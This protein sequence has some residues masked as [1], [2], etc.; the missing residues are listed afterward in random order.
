MCSG[1]GDCSQNRFAE[2]VRSVQNLKQN[3]L[4]EPAEAKI[5]HRELAKR[6]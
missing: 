1:R 3:G 5:L 4:Y 6:L 2:S